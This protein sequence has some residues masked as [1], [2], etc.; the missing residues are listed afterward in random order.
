MC[1][2]KTGH[3]AFTPRNG[4]GAEP[5]VPGM[6]KYALGP[7]Q[8]SM[9]AT[10]RLLPINTPLRIMLAAAPLIA[11]A[12]L[13]A[14]SPAPGANALAGGSSTPGFTGRTIIPGNNSTIAGDAEATEQQ[15]KWP[16][17]RSR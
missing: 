7:G 16:T 2:S 14:C 13:G 10:T 15:Q 5:F 1:E 8:Q 3:I 12:L 17:G 4:V 9:N 6:C 11:I